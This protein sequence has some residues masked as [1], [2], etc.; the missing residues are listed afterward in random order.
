MAITRA[1]PA[2]AGRQPAQLGIFGIRSWPK[3]RLLLA[4]LFAAVSVFPLL[5]MASLSF[6]PPSDVFSGTP[7]LVPTHPTTAN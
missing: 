6:Q 2:R 5:F 3:T 7:V 4:I 1:L